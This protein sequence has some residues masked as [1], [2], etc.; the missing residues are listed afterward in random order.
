MVDHDERAKRLCD[1]KLLARPLGERQAAAFTHA[2]FLLSNEAPRLILPALPREPRNDSNDVRIILFLT[3][4]HSSS[5]YYA[6]IIQN[7]Q[8][9]LCMSR[10]F[11]EV[12]KEN[13]RRL[14][15]V[16]LQSDP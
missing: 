1:A 16:F 14:A 7:S 9:I 12:W 13:D 15:R 6:I 10:I 2:P 8:V 5:E 4:H 3:P 11:E